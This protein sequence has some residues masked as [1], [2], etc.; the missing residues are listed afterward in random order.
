MMSPSAVTI[1]RVIFNNCP[2]ST[3]SNRHVADHRQKD[4]QGADK[5]QDEAKCMKVD[6]KDYWTCLY[7]EI[8]KST[9][10]NGDVSTGHER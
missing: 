10:S 6:T 7:G 8:Q 9:N 3:E 1:S 5:N 4:G 2:L